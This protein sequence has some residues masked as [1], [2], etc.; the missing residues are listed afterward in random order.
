MI[1]LSPAEKLAG[2]SSEP[3]QD[4]HVMWLGSRG[5][6]GRP[7][8]KHL[9][10]DLPAAAVAF[11]LRTGRK[12][13][14]TTRADCDVLHCVAPA[15]VLDDIE[16]RHVR[17]QQRAVHG[18]DPVPWDE[19]PAGHGWDVHGR[20]EP[21]LTPYCKQCTT[22]RARRSRKPKNTKGLPDESDI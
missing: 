22:D 14:G 12:P 15:H 2:R 20:I 9:G 3:D 4:G 10:K 16:R 1:R 13:V 7:V 5:H 19:C 11:E 17:G 8:M 6:H 21:D 18:L